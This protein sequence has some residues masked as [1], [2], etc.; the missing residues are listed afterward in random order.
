MDLFDAPHAENLAPSATRHA[1]LQILQPYV[2]STI[3][4][5]KRNLPH[6]SIHTLAQSLLQQTETNPLDKLQ[7]HQQVEQ[8]LQN[9]TNDREITCIC[10]L[11]LAIITIRYGDDS[12]KILFHLDNALLSGAAI[13][14]LHDCFCILDPVRPPYPS[15]SQEQVVLPRIN[16]TFYGPY[17]QRRV[18]PSIDEFRPFFDS[19]RPLVAERA[20]LEWRAYNTW[21]NLKWMCDWYGDRI[22]PIEV[23]KMALP[24]PVDKWPRAEQSMGTTGITEDIDD[25]GPN[26]TFHETVTTL[27]D[28]IEEY[29][30]SPENSTPSTLV[31]YLAQH[32]LFDQ[33]PGLRADF[34]T[35]AL[36]KLGKLEHINAWFGPAS[37][38]T[39][40]HFDSYDNLLA[41]VVGYQYVRL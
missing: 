15:N 12:A 24:G 29:I 30:I 35:P 36:C 20:I 2:E 4:A 3:H 22:V 26:S 32:P 9:T 6:A 31:G 14:I 17:I 16:Q 37:T 1:L 5:T 28:F 19:N 10:N 38:V 7:A 13:N 34:E 11:M 8:L 18:K 41:Q 27:R 40:L 39:P 25:S 23:G 33:L 21:G